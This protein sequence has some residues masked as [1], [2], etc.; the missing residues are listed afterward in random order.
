MKLIKKCKTKYVPETK[1]DTQMK[2]C[3]KQMKRVFDE[4]YK[5]SFLDG[6]GK[7][8]NCWKIDWEHMNMKI[9]IRTN[10]DFTYSQ[11]IDYETIH[12]CPF[13]G[14]PIKYEVL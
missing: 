13:C 12:Y 14:T 9:P 3:C 6:S 7:W 1:C 11:I 5:T 8:I 2:F 10:Y 4:K